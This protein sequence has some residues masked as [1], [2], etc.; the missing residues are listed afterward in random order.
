MKPFSRFLVA[1][2][3]VCSA[4]L[5]VAATKATLTLGENTQGLAVDSVARKAFVS[6]YATGTISVIDLDA[7][8]V[9]N[10][11]TVRTGVRRSLVSVALNRLYVVSDTVPGYLTVIDT[12]TEQIIADIVV[13]S[14][15]RASIADFQAGEVYVRN[16]NSNSISVVNTASNTVT[17]TIPLPAEP[18]DFTMNANV[19]KIYVLFASTKSVGVYD[20]KTRAFIRSIPVGNNPGSIISNEGSGRVVVLDINDRTLSIIDT[21]IDAVVITL[22]VGRVTAG[23]VVEMN[24][25]WAKAWV[26]NAGDGTVSVIDLVTNKVVATVAVGVAPIQVLSESSGGDVYVV[27]QGSDSVTVLDPNTNAVTGTIPVGGSP[28]RVAA[29]RVNNELLVL[30]TNTTSAPDTLT[31]ADL[32]FTRTDTA[33]AVDYYHAG[34]NH[35]FHSAEPN[36][37]A[38]LDS[39]IFKNNWNRTYQFWR[40]WTQPAAGRFPVCRFFSTGFDPQSSHFFTPYASECAGLQAGTVWQY[41]GTVF[42]I[43]LPD[44]SGNCAADLTPLY[45]VYNNGMGGAPN[46]RYT[47]SRVIRNVML[48]AGWLAEGSGPDT[49]FACLPVLQ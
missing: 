18:T 13:G 40:V 29:T 45:R 31:I 10:T 5:A 24:A 6:N 33:V 20:Q 36:E 47:I 11:I 25:I 37:I 15:P 38:L 26:P 42:Y 17:A 22:P 32:Q 16:L 43:A 46:H 30:N 44:P 23:N 34:F 2:L 27:N 41:E 14:N 49:V 21:A 48:T 35:Y 1:I 19:G 3:L 7:L 4:P 9:R 12:K 39:G 28:W 8:T